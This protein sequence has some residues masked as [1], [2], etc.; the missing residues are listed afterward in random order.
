[1]G[2]VFIRKRSKN[3]IVYLEYK[4]SISSKR[5]Q[6]NMGSF[7][8]KKDANKKMIEI[9]NSILN[10]E[11]IIDDLTIYELVSRY[12]IDKKE[13]L[14]PASYRYYNRIL[15]KYINPL[16]GEIEIHK[17][18]KN[19]VIGYIDKL[20]SS[21]S[22]KTLNIHLNILRQ[23]FDFAQDNDMINKNIV[24]SVKIDT[25]STKVNSNTKTDKTDVLNLLKESSGTFLELPLYLASGAGMKLSEILGLTW[26]N[27]DFSK[28]EI[29]IDKVS[30]REQGKV[31]LKVPRSKSIIRTVSVPEEI[32]DRLKKLKYE[33]SDMDIID[34]FGI[35]QNLIFFDNKAKPIAE[36]VISRKLKQFIKE[37]NLPELTF[38]S[39]RHF[40]VHMLIKAKVPGSVISSR[41]GHSSVSTTLNMYSEIFDKYQEDIVLEASK[42]IFL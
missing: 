6:K 24:K 4:D 40:H 5:K 9:K 7:E 11:F 25:V 15:E 10:D 14:S 16:I 13:D 1:M 23:S 28:N 35:K 39:L 17:L 20:R 18:N 36:D 32:S 29:S 19:D 22:V 31:I 8:K 3:Y 30:S 37:H 26:N 12:L 27:I 41:I 42:S 38:Q 33:H 34:E 21:L 2:S